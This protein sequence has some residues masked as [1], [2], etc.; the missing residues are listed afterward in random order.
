MGA[1]AFFHPRQKYMVKLQPF[2]AVQRNQRH[3]GLSFELIGVADQSRS[4]QKIG[5]R[6]AGF[7][8][9]RHGACEFFQVFHARDVIRAVT[10][11]QHIHVAGL[12]QNGSQKFWRFFFCQRSLKLELARRH[13]A[14]TEELARIPAPPGPTTSSPLPLLLGFAAALALAYALLRRH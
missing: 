13:A 9:F 3:P 6:L 12:F 14:T 2:C 5:K 8:A 4:V 7:H 11:F 1:D 10:I